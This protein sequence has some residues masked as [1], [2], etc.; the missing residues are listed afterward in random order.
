MTFDEFLRLLGGGVAGSLITLSIQGAMARY[1]RPKLIADFGSDVQGAIVEHPFT[2]ET[3]PKVQGTKEQWVRIKIQ[4]KGR[5]A[6]SNTRVMIV[7]INNKATQAKN[8]EFSKEVIDCNWAYIK[9]LSVDIPKDTYRFSDIAR[10]KRENGNTTLEFTG[11]GAKNIPG[12]IER[13]SVTVLISADNAETVTAEIK[14]RYDGDAG[15]V[16]EN[17]S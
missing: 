12:G 6:A 5:S 9:D 10:L 15:M 7:A 8:W 11:I 1:M 2:V 17:A 13:I 16:F 4:N 3:N 14:L